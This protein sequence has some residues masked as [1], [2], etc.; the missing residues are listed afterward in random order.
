MFRYDRFQELIKAQGTTKA[1]IGRILGKDQFFIRDK[2]KHQSEFKP[3]QVA[4]IAEALHTTKE[5]LLGETDDPELPRQTNDVAE[6]LEDLRTR[7]ETR[8]LLEASRGMTKEEV[9][10][11]AD[12]AR[13]LRKTNGID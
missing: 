1:H 10:A 9:L 7:P 5:Y 4:L 11:M 2:I 6:Y 13:K 8:A 12:F 3:F